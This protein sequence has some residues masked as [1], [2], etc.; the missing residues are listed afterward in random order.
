MKK[1][2]RSTLAFLGLAAIAGLSSAV[3]A[4]NVN[5]NCAYTQANYTA[6]FEK[7]AKTRNCPE[8]KCN[9]LITISGSSAVVN[10]VSGFSVEQSDLMI[11]LSRTA[12]DP[13]M[14][15][16]DTT[17]LTINKSDMSFENVKTTT[18]S[19]VLRTQGICK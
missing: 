4:E 15:G 13:I 14:G 7:N 2:F 6:P 8:G 19:V 12:K 3:Q 17:V 10:G 18:P 11:K 5:Y 16:M 9:Y 1:D